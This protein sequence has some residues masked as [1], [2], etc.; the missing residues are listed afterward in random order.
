V[1]YVNPENETLAGRVK[2]GLQIIR[3]NGELDAIFNRYFAEDITAVN[4]PA[5][6]MIKLKNPIL[7]AEMADFEPA[8]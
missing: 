8:L 6:R 2:S 7:P 4:L 5:R 3:T 1:F